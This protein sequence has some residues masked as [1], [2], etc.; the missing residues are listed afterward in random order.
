[1]EL[2]PS[3]E[4]EAMGKAAKNFFARH[5][6]RTAITKTEAGEAKFSAELWAGMAD[7]GWMSLIIPEEHGGLGAGFLDLAAI[8][9]QM[10]S[11]HFISPFLSNLFGSLLIMQAGNDGQKAKLLPEIAAGRRILTVAAAEPD[12]GYDLSNIKVTAGPK[13]D[14][15]YLLNGVKLFVRDADVANDMVCL[16]TIDGESGGS[17]LFIVD[18][19]APGLAI[20]AL[21]TVGGDRQFEVVLDDVKVDAANIL[22]KVGSGYQHLEITLP[23]LLVAQCIE[24]VGGMKRVLD[25]SVEHAKQRVQFDC[26]IGSFQA[27]QHHCANMYV[28]AEGASLFTYRVAWMVEKGLPCAKEAYMCKAW[29]SDAYRRVARL[30]VQVHGGIGVISEYDMQY[31]FRDA[32]KSESLWGDADFFREKVAAKFLD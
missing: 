3:F 31:Y 2:A 8:V 30:G 25:M 4:Q 24:M 11:V 14:G 18:S 9:E 16:A 26:P 23:M 21:K 15:Q 22:G 32:R 13:P 10:G 20:T 6:S 28:A 12:S 19:K 17:T 7:L 1:M 29:V 27:V 5:W